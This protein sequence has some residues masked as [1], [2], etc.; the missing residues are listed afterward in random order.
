MAQ[1]V[2]KV[3]RAPR[4]VKLRQDG[5]PFWFRH[6]CRRSLVDHI[7]EN[8]TRALQTKAAPALSGG[9]LRSRLSRS[10]CPNSHRTYSTS[11]P[12]TPRTQ[13]RYIRNGRGGP[14]PPQRCATSILG[15]CFWRGRSDRSAGV[16]PRLRHWAV[17]DCSSRSSLAEP[18]PRLSAPTTRLASQTSL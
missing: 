5:A 13:C 6:C 8:L 17:A 9:T 7:V 18:L 11:N 14:G 3:E 12:P 15:S 2:S 16:E 4:R 10:P 1:L